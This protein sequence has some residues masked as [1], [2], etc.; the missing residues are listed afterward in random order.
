M[1]FYSG[2][3]PEES[4]LPFRERL[5]SSEKAKWVSEWRSII[6]HSPRYIS[7]YGFVASGAVVFFALFMPAWQISGAIWSNVLFGIGELFC[8]HTLAKF[9]TL[10]VSKPEITKRIAQSLEAFKYVPNQLP[11][12]TSPSVTPAAG[13][14]GAPSVAADH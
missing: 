7:V 3:I 8:A 4:M 12:P 1:H 14:A 2:R 5:S 13:A 6:W 10:G 9:V 11:D